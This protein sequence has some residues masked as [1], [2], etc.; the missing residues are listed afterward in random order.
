MRS[1]SWPGL[2]QHLE[3]DSQE[4]GGRGHREGA[5]VATSQT[6]NPLQKLMLDRVLK[7]G[8]HPELLRSL[9]PSRDERAEILGSFKV[10]L[11]KHN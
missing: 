3:G 6:F 2:L 11:T 1:T 7:E 4:Q 8:I 10:F 9:D 5:N